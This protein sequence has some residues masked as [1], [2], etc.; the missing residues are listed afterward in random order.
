MENYFHAVVNSEGAF[1]YYVITEGEGV[2]KMLTYDYVRR[3]WGL[4][5]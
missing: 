5:L 3:R 1:T 2:S 4:A